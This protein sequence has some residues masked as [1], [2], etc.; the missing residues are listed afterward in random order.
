MIS[1]IQFLLQIIGGTARKTGVY[2]SIN[3]DLRTDLTQQMNNKFIFRR[4]P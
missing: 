4:H 1:K 2:R 3:E